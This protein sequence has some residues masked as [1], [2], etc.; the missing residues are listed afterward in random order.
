MDE[1]GVSPREHLEALRFL[2]WINRWSL[3]RW[4]IGREIRRF[5]GPGGARVL[6]V[7][8]G[9]GDVPQY[10]VERK[11]ARWAVG[12]DRSQEA[13]VMAREL[14]PRVAYVRADARHLPFKDRSFATAISHLFFHHLDEAG[15]LDVTTELNRVARSWIVVDLERSRRLHGIVWLLTRLVG[16]RLTR[17]DGPVSVRRAY[18]AG[19]LAAL[20]RGQDLPPWRL[21]RWLFRWWAAGGSQRVSQAPG[22]QTAQESRHA[23]T[24]AGLPNRD[25]HQPRG[26]GIPPQE[27]AG[28]ERMPRQKEQELGQPPRGAPQR[29]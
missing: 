29:P 5:A 15:C 25:L 27:R 9:G 22:S 6:D 10:L 16:N 12:V 7:A 21:R 18:R 28:R 8:T 17:H 13:I 24:E 14:S 23:A 19:E 1:P 4:G 3:A 2:R 11:I 26:A 20:L